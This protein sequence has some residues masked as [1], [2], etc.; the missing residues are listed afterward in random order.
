MLPASRRHLSNGAYCWKNHF[1]FQLQTQNW[2]IFDSRPLDLGDFGSKVRAIAKVDEKST[3][4]EHRDKMENKYDRI[5]LILVK[6]A[7]GAP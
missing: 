1:A 4:L 7:Q 2:Q 6:T 3:W 5:P